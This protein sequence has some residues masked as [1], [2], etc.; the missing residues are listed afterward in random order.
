MAPVADVRV[1]EPPHEIKGFSYFMA[2]HARLTSEPAHV[3]FRRQ[4]TKIAR[5]I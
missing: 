3:W 4:L 1:V 5:T 2:W